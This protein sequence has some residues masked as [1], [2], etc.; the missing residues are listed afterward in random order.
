MRAGGQVMATN[1]NTAIR[2]RLSDRRTVSPVVVSNSKSGAKAPIGDWVRIVENS[3]N[4]F[5]R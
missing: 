2:P 4:A 1:M 5:F 3:A